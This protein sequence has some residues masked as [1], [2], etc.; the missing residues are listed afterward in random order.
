MALMR[1]LL[2]CWRRPTSLAILVVGA[3]PLLG[4]VARW[5]ES[6]VF[7]LDG[8]AHPHWVRLSVKY[9][10]YPLAFVLFWSLC[11]ASRQVAAQGLPLRPRGTLAL[12]LIGWAGLTGILAY[13]SAN[14][15]DNLLHGR[16]LHWHAPA[17]R[18]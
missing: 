4:M 10:Y 9:G 16:P 17:P 1:I 18:P 15:V 13:S 7:W 8:R 12:L 3:L 6:R 5:R 2:R 11:R 14:N